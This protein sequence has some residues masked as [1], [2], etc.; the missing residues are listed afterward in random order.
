MYIDDEHYK[1]KDDSGPIYEFYTPWSNKFDYVK[2]WFYHYDKAG[3]KV[4]D[5]IQS[6]G[7]WPPP[8]NPFIR[9]IICIPEI[10]EENVTF[11]ALLVICN[12]GGI[13]MF[14]HLSFPNNYKGYIG[15]FLIRATFIV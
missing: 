2:F 15:R 13:H 14:K 9:G 3:N 1:T 4:I 7:W 12:Y 10:S 6:Y 5:K 8:P 11:I